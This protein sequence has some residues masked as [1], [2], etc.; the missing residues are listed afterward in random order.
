MNKKGI[1]SFLV[2]FAIIFGGI[3]IIG[4]FQ[5]GDIEI[6]FDPGER[7][8][9][10]NLNYMGVIYED[11]G[12]IFDFRGGYSDSDQCPWGFPH[13]GIDFFLNN[14]S[15][16]IAAAPGQ[17]TEIGTRINEGSDN[18]YW[19][20]INIRFNSTFEHSYNF[21]SWTTNADD[22]E[23]QQSLINVSVGDWVQKGDFLGKFLS[24]DPNGAHIH[25]DVHHKIGNENLKPC[26]L[27]YYGLTDITEISEMV[28]EHGYTDLLCYIS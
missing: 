11:R 23:H 14:G 9:Q 26:P 22:W 8:Q 17:I 1:F 28:L 24:I 27:N 19:V 5:N 20:N 25:F 15:N 18:K 3:L 7:Y 13:D 12:D 2:I 6:F 4:A 21:E 10:E 16:V